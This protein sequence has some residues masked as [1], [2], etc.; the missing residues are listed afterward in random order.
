MKALVL[1]GRDNKLHLHYY[2]L[3]SD[4]SPHILQLR[5]HRIP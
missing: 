1:E 3:I 2:N 5:I 4:A